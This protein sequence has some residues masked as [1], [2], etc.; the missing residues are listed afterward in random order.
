MPM[1][2]TKDY[3]PGDLGRYDVI[4]VQ[5]IVIGTGTK[6]KIVLFLKGIIRKPIQQI[7]I[8]SDELEEMPD[9]YGWTQENVQAFAKWL[10]Y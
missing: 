9:M 2:A 3:T 1:P 6:I 4:L 7:L 8:L 10:N 5:P